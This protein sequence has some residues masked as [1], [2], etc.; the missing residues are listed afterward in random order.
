MIKAPFRSMQ[1]ILEKITKALNE[2]IKTIKSFVTKIK[3]IILSIR[4]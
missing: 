3:R 1:D 4:E 2:V